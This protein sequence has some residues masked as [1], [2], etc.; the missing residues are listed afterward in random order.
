MRWVAEW[1][2]WIAIAAAICYTPLLRLWWKNRVVDFASMSPA[3]DW[4]NYLNSTRIEITFSDLFWFL[5]SSSEAMNFSF[6]VYLTDFSLVNAWDP[7]PLSTIGVIEDTSFCI[8]DIVPQSKSRVQLECIFDEI[9]TWVGQKYRR[10]SF[11]SIAN[12]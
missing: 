12:C 6:E 10:V 9:N 11:Q 2:C 3:W 1:E 4:S 5:G 8:Q 7:R